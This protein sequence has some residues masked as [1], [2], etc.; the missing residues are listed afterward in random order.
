MNKAK[1]VIIKDATRVKLKTSGPKIN[2]DLMEEMLLEACENN[3]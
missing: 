2:T 3:K 1:N